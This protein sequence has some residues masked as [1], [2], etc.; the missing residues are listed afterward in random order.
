M[1]AEKGAQLN[2]FS[3]SLVKVLEF[4]QLKWEAGSDVLVIISLTIKLLKKLTI[5]T[6]N[7][8]LREL[9][10]SFEKVNW[11]LRSLIGWKM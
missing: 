9:G 8:P 4:N 11:L 10:I 1:N 2:F 6:K 3:S 7:S 5:L